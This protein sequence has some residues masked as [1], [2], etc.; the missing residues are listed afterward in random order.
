VISPYAKQAVI[1]KQTISF[2][3]YDKFIEDAFL[4]GR[5]IDPR[6]D[7]RPDPRT[8]V[9]ENA[10]VLGNLIA[11]FDFNQQPRAPMLLPV[12]PTTTLTGTPAPAPAPG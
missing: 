1:D 11:D 2:D 10:A 12:H 9:R 6:S 4:Q 8:S 5:R 7:G 3:A